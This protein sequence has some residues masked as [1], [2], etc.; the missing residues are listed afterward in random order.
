VIYEDGVTGAC[1]IIVL[2]GNDL[3]I[4]SGQQ[5]DNV[6]PV[7]CPV[8]PGTPANLTF[9]GAD[10]QTGPTYPWTDNQLWNL[11]TLGD[12]DDFDAV[13]RPPRARLSTSRGIRTLC[14][15]H[16]AAFHGLSEHRFR[17]PTY[18]C[19]NWL[20]TVLEVGSINANRPRSNR[21]AG[22]R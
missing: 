3:L 10:G 9:I 6:L 5:I 7:T 1:E 20:V 11:A 13:I 21:K 15:S 14:G 17:T 22:A 18:D 4:A 8:P 19:I 2:D 12:G 16:D